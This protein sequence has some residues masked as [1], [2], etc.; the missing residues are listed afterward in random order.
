M[1]GSTFTPAL[2]RF[3]HAALYDRLAALS[4]EAR[5]RGPLVRHIAPQPDD[6]VV[7]VGCGT[8]TLALLL[9]RAAPEARIVG[10][11]PDPE[12]IAIARR[13]AERDGL[14]I[15]WRQAMGDAAVGAVGAGSAS[16]VV[17]SLVLHQCSMPMKRAI[18]ATMHALLRPGG[19]LVIGDFGLQRTWLMR[20]AFKLVQIADGRTDTQ[21]NADG[22]LP[23]LIAAAGFAEVREAEVIPTVTGSVSI[24]V[25]RRPA[26]AGEEAPTPA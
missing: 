13:K 12:V 3:G 16:I 25:A 2:G 9:R 4:G 11:D 10:V 19:R 5:W 18:L 6:V 21:P 8:G 22:V 17:S 26:A 20:L 1:E 23:E 24:Y 15:E 7:D 14:R